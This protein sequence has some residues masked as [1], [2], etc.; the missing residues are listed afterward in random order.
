MCKFFD[1]WTFRQCCFFA[2]LGEAITF[3][4]HPEILNIYVFLKYTAL[5]YFLVIGFYVAF[6]Y[7]QH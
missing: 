5:N 1:K 4:I 2:F 7:Y 6:D 3:I